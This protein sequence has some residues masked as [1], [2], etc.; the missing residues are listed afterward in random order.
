MSSLGGNPREIIPTLSLDNV[1]RGISWLEQV[2]GFGVES[3]QASF[4]TTM[5]LGDQRIAVSNSLSIAGAVRLHHLALSVP[6][7]DEAMTDCLLRGGKLA[8][9]M[10]PDGPLEIPE[11][12]ESG[13]R[14][15]FFE[16]PEGILIEL[17]AKKKSKS[18]TTWGHSHLGVM[19]QD[20]GKERQVFESLGCNRVAEYQLNQPNGT[21]HVTFLEFGRSLVELFSGEQTGLCN[22]LSGWNGCA[23]QH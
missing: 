22:S 16:G 15:V 1:G 10:T 21:T 23:M 7:V 11:F 12:W 19:C 17:C 13:V 20:V 18:E 3:S 5:V 8:K 2:F 6:E 4:G 14:Y 9:S